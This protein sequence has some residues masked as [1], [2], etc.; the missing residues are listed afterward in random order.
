MEI[1]EYTL[2]DRLK[3]Q[4]F[5]PE[6]TAFF[7]DMNMYDI[8]QTIISAC[9]NLPDNCVGVSILS[10]DKTTNKY[11]DKHVK[12]YVEFIDPNRY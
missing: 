6:P 10:Q 9:N 5:P 11:I 2:I 12:Q 8:P 7:F 4:E 1:I 3:G